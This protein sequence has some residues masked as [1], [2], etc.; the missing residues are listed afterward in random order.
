MCWIIFTIRL[1]RIRDTDRYW[2]SVKLPEVSVAWCG[3]DQIPDLSLEGL[4][5]LEG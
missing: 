5:W 3:C 1:S 2:V 4:E